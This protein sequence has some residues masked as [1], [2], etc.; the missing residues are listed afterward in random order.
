[1]VGHSRDTQLIWGSHNKL[2]QLGQDPDKLKLYHH[3][4]LFIT[5]LLYLS[6]KQISHLKSLYCT[7]IAFGWSHIHL[8]CR[9]KIEECCF[10]TFI[11]H[12]IHCHANTIISR[13]ACVIT[14]CPKR[15]KWHFRPSRFQNV[16]GE[17]APRPPRLRGLTA[18]CSYSRLFFSNQLPTSNFIETP[19]YIIKKPTQL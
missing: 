2:A 3:F 17:H 1:M 5:S 14:W 18:P 8:T 15:W 10:L 19:A 12:R 11:S 13:C 16:L 9:G 4:T 7:A 6:R